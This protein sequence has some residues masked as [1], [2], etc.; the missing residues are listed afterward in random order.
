MRVNVISPQGF[1]VRA[2]RFESGEILGGLK[3][4]PSFASQCVRTKGRWECGFYA[5]YADS[6]VAP[7]FDCVRRVYG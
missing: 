1:V 2:R 5:R 4:H 6:A 7:L 3:W